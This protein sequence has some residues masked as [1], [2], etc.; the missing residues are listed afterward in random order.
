MWRACALAP[1]DLDADFAAYMRMRLETEAFEVE[2]QR[3][4]SEERAPHVTGKRRWTGPCGAAPK[5]ARMS[6]AQVLTT[7]SVAM[8]CE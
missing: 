8:E 4:R 2:V 5:R 3:T 1:E 6:V 7:Q